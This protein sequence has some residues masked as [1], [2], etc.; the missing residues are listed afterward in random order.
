MKATFAL[1][2]DHHVHNM[3]RKLAVEVHH[4]YQTGLAGSQLPPHVSL[5]QP[6]LIADLPAL[7]A[8]FDQ[9]A[10]SINPLLLS[11]PRIGGPGNAPVLWLEVEETETLRQLHTR[12]N[13]ELA[14][15]FSET[16]APF[17]GPAYHF[18]L[19]IALDRASSSVYQSMVA[20]LE[21]R[22]V[23]FQATARHLA[24]FYYDDD[25]FGPASF[26]TYKILPLGPRG[27]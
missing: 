15:R 11:F 7:E 5:K 4:A 13:Q 20:E 22:N 14:E 18:H 3:V 10:K 12:I 2:L 24:L 8:Y 6:F 19:T 27:G 9:L 16:Q 1:L 17:D 23:A 21:S 25:Q 26:L